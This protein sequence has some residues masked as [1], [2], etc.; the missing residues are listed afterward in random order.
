MCEIPDLNGSTV[1]TVSAVREKNRLTFTFDA[2]PT[3][4]K[5]VL[6]GITA[7]AKVEGAEIQT[8]EK[9]LTLGNLTEQVIVTL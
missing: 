8:G 4:G 7:A 3:D 6:E 1:S 5:I 9:A 2:L